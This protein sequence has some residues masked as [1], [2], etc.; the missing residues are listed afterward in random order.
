[1]SRLSDSKRSHVVASKVRAKTLY[2]DKIRLNPSSSLVSNIVTKTGSE[3]LTNKNLTSAANFLTIDAADISGDLAVDSITTASDGLTLLT[4]GGVFESSFTFTS[5]NSGNWRLE[6]TEDA[7]YI[8]N[9]N[10][11]STVALHITSSSAS[12]IWSEELVVKAVDASA[13][14]VSYKSSQ[15]SPVVRAYVRFDGDFFDLWLDYL[16]ASLLE[17]TVNVSGQHSSYEAAAFSV[18]DPDPQV[19]AAI[20]HEGSEWLDIIQEFI[21]ADTVQA[22]LYEQSVDTLAAGMNV[23]ADLTVSGAVVADNVPTGNIETFSAT[24]QTVAVDTS[25][26]LVSFLGVGT[27]LLPPVATAI[28][29]SLTIKKT[30]ADTSAITITADGAEFID[31]SNTYFA[32]DAIYDTIVLIPGPSKWHIASVMLA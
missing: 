10:S 4:N 12:H 24:A 21:G 13:R 8:G 1:M 3:T 7:H 27:V 6:D 18:T 25:L 26:V 17:V 30:G 19:A 16:S 31:A 5:A 15:T 14:L 2:A 20:T 28:M 29:P 22:V 11:L 32:Q 23:L 9:F